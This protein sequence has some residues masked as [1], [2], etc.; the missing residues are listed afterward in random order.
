MKNTNWVPVVGEKIMIVPDASTDMP[1]VTRF[2]MTEYAGKTVVVRE[3]DAYLENP[4]PRRLFDVFADGYWW[5]SCAV[6]PTSPISVCS[7]NDLDDLLGLV[8]G[9]VL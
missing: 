9:N 7:E 1:L 4:N 6:M 3:V 2:M 5:P 8:P